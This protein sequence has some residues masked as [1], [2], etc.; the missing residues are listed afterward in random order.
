MTSVGGPTSTCWRLSR[1]GVFAVVATQLAALGHVMGGGRLPD[2]TVLFTVTVSLGGSLSGLAT[3][4]R[5][6][7]QIL[8]ALLLSQLAFH[9]AFQVTAHSAHGPGG[10]VGGWRMLA[11]HLV[12]GLLAAWVMAGAESMVFRL[13]AAL[14]RAIVSRPA[15]SAVATTPSWTAVIIGRSRLGRLQAAGSS[16]VARRGPPGNVVAALV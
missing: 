8:L 1:A 16:L 2:P 12:A 3:R 11:F 15:R 14:H 10:W 7:R 9:A 13:Y 6:G 4:R 5:S